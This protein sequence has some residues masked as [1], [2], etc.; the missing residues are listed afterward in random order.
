MFSLAVS[1]RLAFNLY[2]L[3]HNVSRLAGTRVISMPAPSSGPAVV[4]M[5]NMLE[6][7][8][9]T[10][11]N[12][13]QSNLYQQMVEVTSLRLLSAWQPPLLMAV[14]LVTPSIDHGMPLLADCRGGVIGV[15]DGVSVHDHVLDYHISSHCIDYR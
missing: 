10:L 14:C 1:F 11:A 9:W 2:Q 3:A 6:G 8:N 4:L 5:L 12:A 7:F 13:S 15:L